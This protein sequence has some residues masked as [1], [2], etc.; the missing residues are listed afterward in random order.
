MKEGAEEKREK[1][2]RRRRGN[3]KGKE[4]ESVKRRERG[5]E[6]LLPPVIFPS[7]LR[8]QAGQDLQQSTLLR[9]L[10]PLT[11]LW[12]APVQPTPLTHGAGKAQAPK[13]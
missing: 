5:R 6:K 9:N 4:R 7:T 1:G 11:D 13:R 10:H 2:R 12:R 8:L 3:E